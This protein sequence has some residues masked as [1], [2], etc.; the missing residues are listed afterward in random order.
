MSRDLLDR[1]FEPFSQDDDLQ[2]N[3]G[4]LGLGLALVRGLA[5][6]HGGSA[7]A[8][9]AGPGHG[10]EFIIRLPAAE[11]PYAGDKARGKK[12]DGQTKPVSVLL[13]EDN[14][15]AA[16]SLATY[17]ELKGHTVHIA[18]EGA[19]GVDLARRNTPDV[20]LCDLGL[21]GAMDGFA[22]AREV[23]AHPELRSVHLIALTGYGQ[24]RDRERTAEAGFDR[25]L[26]KP[27]DLGTLVGIIAN[28][29]AGRQGAKETSA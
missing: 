29:G 11:T 22:V 5:E 13:I 8:T 10:S 3:P 6:L 24:K 16:R 4:G 27:V 26:L 18:G 7:T 19:A 14:E 2:R 15:D 12:T 17:L 20:I 23:R 28:T 1:L 21:P 25:H 9:S